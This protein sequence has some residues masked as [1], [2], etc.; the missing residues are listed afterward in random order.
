MISEVTMILDAA[1]RPK[2][3]V[4]ANGGDEPLLS[5]EPPDLATQGDTPGLFIGEYAGEYD[6][7]CLWENVSV[8]VSRPGAAPL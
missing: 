1:H 2:M 3:Q 7:E 5:F 6:G 8:A 4:F